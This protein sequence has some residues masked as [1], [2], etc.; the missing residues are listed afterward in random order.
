MSKSELQSDRTNAGAAASPSRCAKKV[1]DIHRQFIDDFY[2]SKL[3]SSPTKRD[4]AL[5]FKDNARSRR[6][7]RG[8]H[9]DVAIRS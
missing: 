9:L 8:E 2:D 3:N 6:L 1:L 4:R 5:L 7:S